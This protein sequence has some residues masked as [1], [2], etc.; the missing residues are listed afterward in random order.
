MTS[1]SMEGRYLVDLKV[2]ELKL[3]LEK[4]GKD[5]NGIKSALIARLSEVSHLL[6]MYVDQSVPDVLTFSG[7]G[8]RGS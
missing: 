2:T 8:R 5:K 1:E 6:P 3:E 4:R 7:I